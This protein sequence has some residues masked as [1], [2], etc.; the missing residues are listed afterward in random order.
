[1]AIKGLTCKEARSVGAMDVLGK[2]RKGD[3]KTGNK[4][5]A[6][7]DYFRFDTSDRTLEAILKRLY[8]NKPGDCFDNGIRFFFAKDTVEENMPTIMAAYKGGSCWRMCDG[9]QIIGE[10][11]QQARW[12]NYPAH[13]RPECKSA[14]D[15][16]ATGKLRIV[17]PEF[18][19]F[20]VV[21]VVVGALND[22]EHVSK[23]LEEIE[24]R[25]SEHG[26][27]LS[28]VPLILYRKARGISCPSGD[29][30]RARRQK[31][32]V[33]VAIAPEFFERSLEAYSRRALASASSFDGQRAIAPVREEL[34][35]SEFSDEFGKR[36]DF[37]YKASTDW[38]EVKMAFDKAR[39][40]QQVNE[41]YT[42]AMAQISN[43]KLPRSARNQVSIL[44]DNARRRIDDSGVQP[45]PDVIEAEVMASNADRF[46]A[47]ARF[48]GWDAEAI[49]KKADALG[50]GENTQEWSEEDCARLRSTLYAFAPALS[51]RFESMDKAGD[52][53]KSFWSKFVGDKT[54]DELVWAEW[55]RSVVSGQPK[56]IAAPVRR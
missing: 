26:G 12:Q 1:M 53:Y 8:G 36:A 25:V 5:G 21:E 18:K 32:M 3:K 15:C 45:L 10:R 16:T 11:D 39:S 51:G 19:R 41:A 33:E 27:S 38:G 56:E 28:Q 47:I 30:K 29:G 48:T 40:H 55:Q 14:C 34:D 35:T 4:P 49:A 37:S 50:M 2:L 17:I 22:L 24:N 46:I 31:S 23:Q 6:D 7:L 44:A 52:A 9:E 54:D 43:G 20:G 42:A 13:R